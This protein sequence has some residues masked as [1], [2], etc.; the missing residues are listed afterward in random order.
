MKLAEWCVSLLPV[1]TAAECVTAGH[2]SGS[3][4]TWKQKYK[5]K[6]IEVTMLEKQK[7]KQINKKQL[8]LVQCAPKLAVW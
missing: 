6:K 2:H 8:R 5:G 1:T 3:D 7:Y 4:R